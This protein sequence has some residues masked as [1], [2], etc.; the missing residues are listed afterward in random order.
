M[1]GLSPTTSQL[2]KEALN[3]RGGFTWWYLD[4]I[5]NEGNGAVIIWSY[6]L[7][8][9]PN[10][11]SMSKKGKGLAARLRPSLN[12]SLYRAFQPAFYLLQ[13]Y[14]PSTVVWDG[15]SWTFGENKFHFCSNPVQSELSL[16][17]KANVPQHSD[18]LEGTIRLTGKIRT[19][20]EGPHSEEHHWVPILV[21]AQGEAALRCGDETY[22]ISGRG[23]HDHNSGTVPLH[24]LDIDRW[25]WGRIALP[26]RELIWYSLIPKNETEPIHISLSV[27]RNGNTA[28]KALQEVKIVKPKRSLYG[29][30]WPTAFEFEAPWGESVRVDTCSKIDD[31]PFYQRYI[32][33]AQCE[34][35]E[36]YGFAE[37]VVP[38]KVDQDWMRPLVKMRVAATQNNSFWLPLFCGPTQGRWSRLIQQLT[39]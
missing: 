12:I 11:A 16:N 17:I 31:G 23:Y 19:G 15:S 2:S 39:K 1:I 9:L 24:A 5:D 38:D 33:K 27:D 13:E 32:I 26:D 10:Y 8:F 37:Q 28:T 7:P 14:D 4:L 6:G 36:G 18:V 30:S 20:G 3:S 25:W 21:A 34:L 22:N 35:G 29:L